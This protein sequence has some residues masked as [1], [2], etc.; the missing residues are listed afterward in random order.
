M[1]TKKWEFEIGK[2]ILK[3][4]KSKK[5]I[6]NFFFYKFN[7]LFSKMNLIDYSYSN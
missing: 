1:N 4:Q 6:K 2:R 3:H 5:K 7:D